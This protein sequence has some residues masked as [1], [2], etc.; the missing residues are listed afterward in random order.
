MDMENLLHMA[1]KIGEFFASMPNRDEALLGIASY[2]QNF[3]A[4]RMRSQLL[5]SVDAV[6]GEG[7][8]P[9]VYQAICRHR[10]NL[11]LRN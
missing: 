8:T 4:P 7:L 6:S 1:N 10:S 5:D 9:I 2:I 3:W 11:L